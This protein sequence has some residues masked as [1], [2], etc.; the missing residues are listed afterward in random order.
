VEIFPGA[1]CFIIVT[2]PAAYIYK[3]LTALRISYV[4]KAHTSVYYNK[5]KRW[6]TTWSRG[7][8]SLLSDCEGE[9]V[10]NK[11]HHHQRVYAFRLREVRCCSWL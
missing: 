7:S 9:A 4:Q 11:Y 3:Y 5:Y 2:P 8:S 10:W 1:H 6:K